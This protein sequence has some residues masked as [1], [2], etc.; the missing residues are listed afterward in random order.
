MQ[1]QYINEAKRKLESMTYRNERAIKF[2]KSIAN[3]VKAVYDLEIFDRRMH[4]AD[5]VDLIWNKMT[6]TDLSQYVTSLNIQFKW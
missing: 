5:V 6:N 1:E 2:E 4:N 3:F